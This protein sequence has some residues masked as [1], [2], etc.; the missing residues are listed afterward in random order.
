MKTIIKAV[1]VIAA[2][3]TVRY[4]LINCSQ[5]N[6]NNKSNEIEL[7]G[8]WDSFD[9]TMYEAYCEGASRG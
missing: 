1:L 3:A 9:D 2:V 5:E 8:T 7:V 4:Y 6:N